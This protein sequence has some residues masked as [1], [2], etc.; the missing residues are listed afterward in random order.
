MPT[1]EKTG[2]FPDMG[3]RTTAMLRLDL[4]STYKWNWLPGD[5]LS[6][7]VIFAATVPVALA[8]SQLAGLKP[9]NGL[10]ASLL[11][12]GIYAFFG[13]SRQLIIGTEAVVAILVA[14]SVGA[15]YS[16]GDP[17]R[18]TT[19]VMLQAIMVGVMH[20]IAGVFRLGYLA[21]FVPKSVVT[22]FIN[23]IALIVILSQ[24]GR[25]SGIELQSAAF[26]PRIWEIISRYR[27]AHLTTLYVGGACLLG[28]LV[29]RP[30]LRRLPDALV[31]V[32]LAS[33]AMTKLNLG[34]HGLAVIGP[35]PAGLPYPTIPEVG[36]TDF[37]TLF[38]VAVGVALVS[39]MDTTIT[40][41]AFAMRGGYRLDYNQEL[42]ALGLA[43]VGTGFFQG[44]AVGSSHPRTAIHEMYGGRSQFAGLLAAILLGVFLLYFTPIL[45]NIPLVALSAIIMVSGLRLLRLG[46]L[47]STFKTRPDSCYVCIATTLA[48]LIAGLMIGILVSVGLA[49]ILVLHHLA[50]PHET[51]N[52]P[53]VAPGLA[54]YRFAGPL[55]FINAAY[56]ANRVQEIIDSSPEPVTF[57]LINAE[58]I[59]DMDVNAAEVLEELQFSLKS[60]GI[61]L[62]ICEVK[63]HFRKVLMSTHLPGRVGFVIYPS[64]A[65]AVRELTKDKS[66]EGKKPEEEPA[67]AP[68]A[69][70]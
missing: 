35:V 67:S 53:K 62:G 63:G 45:K 68:R 54:I 58:A 8:F 42:I 56:F 48:V 2:A 25:I 27:E 33:L 39:Y 13:T 49:I 24:V 19:L 52:R 59:V 44:F 31:V 36:F 7:L 41:R 47:V 3:E 65:T 16:G 17:A 9:V 51:V 40:G 66:T 57:F 21:D 46:E 69:E 22:G 50:R 43:N 34:A 4:L 1:K 61:T 6:G 26:F 32:V 64:V 60:Q 20:I 30:L 29:L 18:F 70:S 55:F 14:T 12:M 37:L 23:G 38:P 10:Y 11:A 15:V 5:L 28:M